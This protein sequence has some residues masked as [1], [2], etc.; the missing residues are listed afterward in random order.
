MEPCYTSSLTQNG[1]DHVKILL[2]LPP[3]HAHPQ[4]CLLPL[5]GS[6][7]HHCTWQYHHTCHAI[8]RGNK[9]CQKKYFLVRSTKSEADRRRLYLCKHR[10]KPRFHKPNCRHRPDKICTHLPVLPSHPTAHR[11]QP[12]AHLR[13]YCFAR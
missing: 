2:V 7:E 1:N 10:Q 9:Y 11:R 8:S 5:A 6:E 12:A 13:L 3:E 4:S